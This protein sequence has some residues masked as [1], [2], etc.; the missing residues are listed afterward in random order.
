MCQELTF[1]IYI[2]SIP[3]NFMVDWKSMSYIFLKFKLN[4]LI[5]KQR[6]QGIFT[7]IIANNTVNEFESANTMVGCDPI[8]KL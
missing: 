3:W 2:K 5:S 7:Y 4:L 1:I 8:H 6:L